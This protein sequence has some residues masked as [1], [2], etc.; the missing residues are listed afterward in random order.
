MG[1]YIN[2][3]QLIPL[4]PHIVDTSGLSSTSII[5]GPTCILDAKHERPHNSIKQKLL[6]IQ[7]H[8]GQ[9]GCDALPPMPIVGKSR[10][11]TTYH[12]GKSLEQS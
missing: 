6:K 12:S 8:L 4:G 1:L 5:Q 10:R 9:D 2:Q 3:H 11:Q 7:P